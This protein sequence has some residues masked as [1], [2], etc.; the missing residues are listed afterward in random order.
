MY[1][2][3][4]GNRNYSSW[5]LRGWLAARLSGAPFREVVVQL[6]GTFNSANLAFSPTALVPALHDGDVHVWD[7]M[8]IAEYLAE[9]HPGM[10]PADPA[11]RAWA[12]SIAAEMHSGFAALRNEMAMCIRER[13]DV[14]PWS[15][16]LAANIARVEQIWNDS[17]RRHGAGGAFLCGPFSLADAFYAPVAFRFQTYGVTPRGDAAD[18]L[19]TLLGHPF[20]REWESAAMAETTVLEADEPRVLYRDK[21]SAAGRA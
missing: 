19:R 3:Y 14:R 15:D 8:A 11:T 6:T 7:T 16:A 17:R 1:T 12:R 13:V 10:W 4:I 5:S 20:V 18:Y 9:R 21:L 2:L